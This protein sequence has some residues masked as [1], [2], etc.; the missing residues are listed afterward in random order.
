LAKSASGALPDHVQ[1]RNQGCRHADIER[2]AGKQPEIR[3]IEMSTHLKNGPVKQR[4]AQSS[5]AGHGRQQDIE[6]LDPKLTAILTASRTQFLRYLQHRL[7]DRDEAEDVLQDFHMRVLAKASQIRDTGSTMAWL[8]AVLKSVLADHFRR[9]AA[10]RNARQLMVADWLATNTEQEMIPT[11]EEGFD[12]IACNCFYKLLP[13]LKREYADALM[14]I[15]LAQEPREDVAR[16]LGITAGNMRVRLHR[17]RRALKE[18]LKRSWRCRAHD[19][20]G[21]CGPPGGPERGNTRSTC[22]L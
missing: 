10:E 6:P 3:K 11:E 19:C 12:R 20:F 4:L 13:T 17:A 9:A 21:Q 1:L 18:T 7:G 16:S 8:R 5:L 15:D 2:P 22:E 14:R